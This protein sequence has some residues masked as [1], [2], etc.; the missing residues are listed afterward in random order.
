MAVVITF[1]AFSTTYE[2]HIAE[3]TLK[4]CKPDVCEAITGG[5]LAPTESHERDRRPFEAARAGDWIGISALCS[6]HHAGMTEPIAT[7]SG[8]RD[9]RAEKRRFL[10]TSLEY[11]V[12]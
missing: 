9:C 12:Y 5:V 3:K 11:K 8:K 2:Q 6:D 7:R 1:P 10:V 4:D